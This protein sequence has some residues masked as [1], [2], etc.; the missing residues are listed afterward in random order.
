MLSTDSI[1]LDILYSAKIEGNEILQKFKISY[2]DK[3]LAEENNTILVAV[4]SS[5]NNLNS[6]DGQTFKDLVEILVITKHTV[7]TNAP[8]IKLSFFILSF[9]YM[10]ILY[11]F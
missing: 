9:L 4:V 5:E 3:Q 8:C 11:Y 1:I 7:A 2:P 10:L 6:F